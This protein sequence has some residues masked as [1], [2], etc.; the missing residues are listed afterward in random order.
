MKKDYN[1]IHRKGR[2]IQVIFKILPGKEINTGTD[3]ELEAVKFAE[4]Y[5]Q[6]FDNKIAYN[7]YTF[8]EYASGFFINDKYGY[9]KRLEK[10]KKTR[11]E[12]YWIS[13]EGM[14]QNYWIPK[15]GNLILSAIKSHM[16][17]DWYMELHSVQSG[18][19]LADNTKNNILAAGNKIFDQ[20][21]RDN[22]IQQNPIK[23]IITITQE[24]KNREDFNDI[25]MA[26]L[27]P[28]D[29]K[30][31]FRIWLSLKWI[32]YFL[33]MRDTGWRPGEV[34]GLRRK[35]FYKTFNGV[36]T[37]RSINRH[38]EVMDRIKTT[39][40]GKNYKLGYLS[41]IAVKQLKKYLEEE[42]ILLNDL[43]FTSSKG[44]GLT[45]DVSNK[46]FK[47]SCDRAGIK[48]GN[49][50]QYCLRH[51]FD[52]KMLEILDK[53]TV[54]ALMGHTNYRK[55]YDHRSPETLLKQY[56]DVRDTIDKNFKIS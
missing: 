3:D 7:A 52:T 24:Q 40:K 44:S 43:I 34:A 46:H 9:R 53:E 37:E 56:K 16:I 31:L 30:E 28:E 48:R 45:P 4:R 23:D 19:E 12:D 50:T 10:K 39:G 17:D 54:N 13:R 2:K 51:T 33:I 20:A 25:E 22:L 35:D 15:F 36:Y 32:C 47:A 18:K 5:L 14:I 6:D 8:K 26:K 41:D 49:R 11:A 55:E 29:E 42:N 1:F 27:F 21:V 38:G